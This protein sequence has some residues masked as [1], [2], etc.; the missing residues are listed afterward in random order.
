MNILCTG[1]QVDDAMCDYLADVFRN[2]QKDSE[3]SVRR[4]CTSWVDK[5]IVK[6]SQKIESALN[7]PGGRSSKELP[8]LQPRRELRSSLRCRQKLRLPTPNS[9]G[10]SRTRSCGDTTSS[11]G[12]LTDNDSWYSWYMIMRISRHENQPC[13]K[14]CDKKWEFF[15][16]DTAMEHKPTDACKAKHNHACEQDYSDR[17]RTSQVSRRLLQALSFKEGDGRLISMPAKKPKA[18]GAVPRLSP[19][20]GVSLLRWASSLLKLLKR[21]IKRFCE[22]PHVYFS[23]DVP[24]TCSCWNWQELHALLGS[25]G[26]KVKA[27]EVLMLQVD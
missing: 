3:K 10:L 1:R 14:Y 16:A 22:S 19:W 25:K 12:V 13:V 9:T 17:G 21:L 6:S 23:L 11:T 27:A 18:G 15:S 26:F 4:S 7:K 5:K 2:R 8:L 20:W 24:S